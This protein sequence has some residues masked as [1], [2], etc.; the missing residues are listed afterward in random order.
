MT[1]SLG[2]P[3]VP[4]RSTDP[5]SAVGVTRVPP[6]RVIETVRAICE[7]IYGPMKYVRTDLPNGRVKHLLLTPRFDVANF[8]KDYRWLEVDI[9][10]NPVIQNSDVIVTRVNR[11][12]RLMRFSAHGGIWPVPGPMDNNS[13]ADKEHELLLAIMGRLNDPFAHVT[14]WG[15]LAGDE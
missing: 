6:E 10:F 11:T 2:S 8:R 7:P 14:Q 12:W 13:T 15:K 1:R 3:G 4:D 9:L 5:G